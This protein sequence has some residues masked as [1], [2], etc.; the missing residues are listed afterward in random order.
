[1]DVGKKNSIPIRNLREDDIEVYS[2]PLIFGVTGHRNLREDD[3]EKLEESVRS[4]FVKY[5]TKYEHTELIVI[6]ALAEG[7]DMLVARVAIELNIT[8][9]IVIPY[10]EEEYLNSFMNKEKNINEFNFLKGEAKSFKVNSSIDTCKPDT[11]YQKLGEYIADVSNILLALWDGE[12]STKPGGTAAIVKY[13]RTGFEENRFDSLDGNALFIITTPRVSNP[14]VQTNFSID[15]ECLGKH[16]KDKEFE[17]MLGKIDTLNSN[18]KI[19]ELTDD[20]LLKTYMNYFETTAGIN[21]TKFKNYSKAI[22]ILTGIAIASLEIMHV[23]HFDNFIIGYIIG[24]LLAFGL[25]RF[26]MKNGQVQDDFVYSRGFVEAL[27]IQN[28]WNSSGLNKSVAKYYLKDQ[29]YK[30]IWLKTTLKNIFY[31]D[32]TPFIPE[33]TEDSSVESWINGQI[34]YFKGAINERDKKFEKWEFV[35][36]IFYWIGFI[37]L[38]L[39]FIIYLGETTHLI[40]HELFYKLSV[41]SYSLGS[42]FESI[43]FL[44]GDSV[45][46]MH[47]NWHVLVLISGLS[48]L[49]AAF[50]GEKYIKI[51]GYE[52]DIYHFNAM[53]SD[54]EDAKKALSDTENDKEKWILRNKKIVYDL[55]LKALEENTKWV[56]LHDSMRAKPSLD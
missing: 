15:T 17:I 18:M 4:L 1:M 41:G 12:D 36:K 23:L 48:L 14:D 55:G 49:V 35:E 10:E 26:F 8:L 38:V 54:F 56:V 5:Q 43:N 53:L 13:Q 32:K 52:E 19:A 16:I 29:H 30:F 20:S 22:L 24:L 31:L 9:H 2:I 46:H 21:Q 11:C 37:F 40:K 42:I 33:Y 27:R 7:S 28:A 6:S 45:E 34:N 39:M 25:Y 51:E 50:I 3:I 47:L 44:K